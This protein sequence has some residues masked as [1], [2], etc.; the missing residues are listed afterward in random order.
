[1]EQKYNSNIQDKQICVSA[2]VM[3]SKDVSQKAK[4]V[5]GYLCSRFVE[6]EKGEI[7][8]KEICADLGITQNTLGTCLNQLEENHIIK[9]QANKEDDRKRYSNNMYFIRFDNVNLSEPNPVISDKVSDNGN[10]PVISDKV[11][12]NNDIPML[13][14]EA[15]DTGTTVV[16]DELISDNH[17]SQSDTV[18]VQAINNETTPIP[19]KEAT[20]SKNVPILSDEV[21]DNKKIPAQINLF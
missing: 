11:T 8:R 13:S 7:S 15:M 4:L 1:M 21:T 3:R 20:D 17:T 6:A 14:D 10:N 16:S 12:D 18:T 9:R 5:Y 19:S 2:S